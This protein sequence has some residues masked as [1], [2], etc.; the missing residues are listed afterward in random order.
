MH[1]GCSLGPGDDGQAIITAKSHLMMSNIGTFRTVKR[2]IAN[3]TLL[4][5]LFFFS[6]VGQA[7]AGKICDQ[8]ETQSSTRKFYIVSP[9]SCVLIALNCI[10][11]IV[12][13]S[14]QI[15]IC[16]RGATFAKSIMVK[17]RCDQFRLIT[18]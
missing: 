17:G 8:P 5:I 6:L 12:S 11:P 16:I 2:P 13:S 18:S 3:N 14:F 4:V 9:L 15:A 1:P 7:S 10:R